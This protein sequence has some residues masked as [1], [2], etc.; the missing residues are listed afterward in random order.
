M[1]QS[2]NLLVE[3]ILGLLPDASILTVLELKQAGHQRLTEHLGAL[4]REKRR[5]VVNADHTERSALSAVGQSNGYCGLVKGGG[6]VVDRNW[7]VGVGPVSNI[8]GYGRRLGKICLTY[9]RS[10]RI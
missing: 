7:V 4:T 8:S 9:Q 10:R 3:Q 5:E 1:R 6:D 2:S